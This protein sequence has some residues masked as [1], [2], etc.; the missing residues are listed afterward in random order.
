MSITE[1]NELPEETS[2]DC[3]WERTSFG[4]RIDGV[5]KNLE[6]QISRV[7][8][9]LSS[10]ADRETLVGSWLSLFITIG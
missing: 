10:L 9:L 2:R 8:T 3:K 7:E 5:T 6:L 1:S 4:R